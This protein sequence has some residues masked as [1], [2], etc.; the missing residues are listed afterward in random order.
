ML[1]LTM[2][3]VACAKPAEAPPPPEPV[4]QASEPDPD[5]QED[6]ELPPDPLDDLRGDDDERDDE[7]PSSRPEPIEVEFDG[8]I[9]KEKS[10]AAVI[11]VGADSRFTLHMD[12]ENVEPPTPLLPPGPYKVIIHSPSRTFRGPTPGRGKRVHF[13]LS[14]F[15]EDPADPHDETFFASLWVE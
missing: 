6:Y 9:T 4:A 10:G 3:M 13:R 14:I 15:P 11:M 1:L 7:A 12:I 2:L 8:V 5:T